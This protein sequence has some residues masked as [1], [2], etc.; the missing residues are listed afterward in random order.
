MKRFYKEA[1]AVPAKDGW[2]V[3][4]DGR[5]VKTANGAAQI[6]RSQRLAEAL[7]LEWAEQGE[8][9]DPASFFLRDLADYAIDVARTDREDTIRKLLGYA[10]TDTLCYRADPDEHL[11]KRQQEVWEPL[12]KRM[13]A[14]LGI[15]LERVSGIIHRAQ[16]EASLERLRQILAGQDDLTLA[17][18]ATLA[19]LSASLTIALAALEPDA[20]AEALW[21]AANLEE[22]WQVEQWGQDSLA[23]EHR[24]N[25]LA[26][27]TNALRF[28]ALA[29]AE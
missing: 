12:L 9:I 3:A 29:R 14:Q 4:L 22:D 26:G 8:E 6:V 13:E 27:F 1:A 19:S 21:S 28:A 20:D 17:A 10:E 25:R 23:Q 16:P 11:Y 2:Q 5:G 7:A 24:A 15:R 18:L